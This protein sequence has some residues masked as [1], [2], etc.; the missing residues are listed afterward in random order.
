M[1]VADPACPGAICLHDGADRVW[2][3]RHGGALL[4]WTHDGQAMLRSAAPAAAD[5][6]DPL[7]TAS[8][9]L[10]PY[11]NRIGD[12]RFAWAGEARQLAPNFAPEPHAIHGL[13][14]RRDWAVESQS[15]TA[16]TLVCH[17]APD[18][19]WPWAFVARQTI[20]VAGGTVSLGHAAENQAPAPGPRGVGP[21]P[22]FDSAGAHLQFAAATVWSNGADRL[23]TDAAPPT[24]RFDFAG[25][26]DVAGGVVDHCYEEWG[27]QATVAWTG[28]RYRLAI[29][30]S[31]ALPCAVVYIPAD[32]G[33]FCFEPVPHANNALNRPDAAPMPV[34][35]PGAAFQAELRL[36]ANPAGR[37]TG[38]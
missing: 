18:A 7:G 12:A 2:L 5:G 6:S 23:P 14:W 13:G 21:H 29:S 11:S 24:G 19:D 38:G 9:P 34:V 8:F 36:V 22:K 35:A 17:H 33:A 26:A 27:G 4:G 30:A 3:T 28:R 16:V 10:V 1:S 32:G 25:G 15:A 31:S 37:P 20:A